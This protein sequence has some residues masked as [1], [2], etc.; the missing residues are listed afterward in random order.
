MTTP[1]DSMISRAGLAVALTFGA[2]GLLARQETPPAT[3]APTLTPAPAQPPQA[4][5]LHPGLLLGLRAHSVKLQMSVLPVVVI[6]PDGPSYV[7]AIAHWQ[8]RLRYPVLI[9]NGSLPAR[10]DIARFV[11]AFKPKSVVRWTASPEQAAKLS[12]DAGRRAKAVENAVAR[13]FGAD[14]KNP[15]ANLVAFWK[16]LGLASPGVV[17]TSMDDHAWPA[18]LALAAGHGQPIVWYSGAG[19]AINGEMLQHEVEAF[20][21]AIEDGVEATG[22]SWRVLGDELDAVSL[23][24]NHAGKFKAIPD[25]AVAE[26]IPMK[27]GEACA[28][29]DRIGR[30][31]EGGAMSVRWAYAGQ[32]FGDEC[33]S[34]YRAMCSLF[35]ETTSAW[36]FDGYPP[37]QGGFS[38][39]DCTKAE[40]ILAGAGLKTTLDDTPRQGR[41]DWRARIATPLNAG[42]A[43]VN[44]QGMSNYFDLQPGRGRCGDVPLLQIPA[45]IHFVHSWSLA[46]P[47]GRDS[48]GGRW[49]EHGAYCYFGSVHEPFLAAFIPTPAVAF[50]LVPVNKEVISGFAW[51]AAGRQDNWPVWRVACIGDPL[52]TIGRPAPRV[53]D[54]KLALSDVADVEEEM[55][56]A[57]KAKQFARAIALLTILGR[58]D[59]AARV[60]AAVLKDD[61]A[62]FG[63]DVAAASIFPLARAGRA[64]ALVGAYT[65][66]DAGTAADG[67]VQD[68]LWLGTLSELKTTTDRN[69]LNVLRR[70]LRPSQTARDALDLSGA[71]DRN[72]GKQ[73]TLS[74]LSEVRDNAKD[75]EQKKELD[76]AIKGFR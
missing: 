14:E 60:A 32:I 43:L 24:L 31:I 72:L 63:P 19:D 11:R 23:C 37:D 75:A 71:W 33:Q 22:L 38:E 18:G 8:P 40:Q 62:K 5:Q 12:G 4:Q 26:R 76:D 46:Y 66:L 44:T 64:D 36:L 59:Q 55:K 47:G 57:V 10:E 45:M 48:I 1:F 52:A 13:A 16:S 21:K 50:R 17:V 70:N 30:H 35:L 2:S 3:P 69:L 42:L 68:A 53:D 6:V 41:A 56:A 34:A 67:F 28:V 29:T 20:E 49:I 27:P 51:G 73:A 39:F 7:E 58:D 9:D 74:M 15:P 65:K 25:P 61:G 54:G